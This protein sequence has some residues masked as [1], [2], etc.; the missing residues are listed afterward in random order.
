MKLA[1]SLFM[2]AICLLVF[3]GEA[4]AQDKLIKT[5][6]DTIDCVV[7]EIGDLEIKYSQPEFS[8]SILFGID[9]DDVKRIELS[10]G[11]A[12]SFTQSLF[13]PEKYAVNHK[14]IIKINF[15]SPLFNSVNLVYER[16]LRPGRSI[17][18][19]LGFI[20]LGNDIYDAD[21]KGLFVKLGYKFIKSPDY[22]IRGQR[23]A[24]LLKGAY[25]RPELAVS[26]YSYDQE[27]Y[28]YGYNTDGASYNYS[29][30]KTNLMF[31]F[32]LNFGKQWV[33]ENGF[34][35][36]TFAA[37]GYAFGDDS[38]SFGMHKAF[39]GGVDE[40]PLALSLGVRIGWCF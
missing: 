12:L 26:Y 24:H 29:D 33:I 11:K 27:I 5:N 2:G 8:E 16:S 34:V 17:E 30:R 6:N 20:G 40:F 10:N 38:E 22:Y 36:D 19:T 18:G 32:L 13:D 39:I 37:V 4:S 21:E 28:G 7:K 15:L 14:N 9:K 31:A 3:A 23:Y 35:V 1:T 25:M